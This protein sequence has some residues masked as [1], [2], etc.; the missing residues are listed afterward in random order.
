MF[1]Q[2]FICPGKH[3]PWDTAYNPEMNQD[4]QFQDFPTDEQKEAITAVRNRL[5]S[6]HGVET[7]HL[8]DLE[9]TARMAAIVEIVKLRDK[10]GAQLLQVLD[11]LGAT[12]LDF[13]AL[14]R[15]MVMAAE[16]TERQ[17]AVKDS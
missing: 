16:E 15:E 13:N 7:S 1:L 2:G 14:V 3:T 5:L 6:E 4:K 12:F 8:D 11:E 17:Q 9:M 10:E